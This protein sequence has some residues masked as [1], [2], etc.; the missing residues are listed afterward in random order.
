MATES[1]ARRFSDVS[2]LQVRKE[3]TGSPTG[4]DCQGNALRLCVYVLILSVPSYA[5][6]ITNWGMLTH[7]KH[8][9]EGE[10]LQTVKIFSTFADEKHAMK[11]VAYDLIINFR[12]DLFL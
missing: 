5:L 12:S 7:F 10:N 4:T 8:K 1:Q 11:S 9:I 2:K 6:A 3:R